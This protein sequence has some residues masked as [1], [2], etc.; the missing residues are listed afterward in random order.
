MCLFQEHGKRPREKIGKER[1]C[2]F[3]QLRHR[4]ELKTGRPTHFTPTESK[5]IAL[6]KVLGIFYTLFCGTV[7]C[8]LL[9]GVLL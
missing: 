6:R 3:Y 1:I 2:T 9:S 4:S 8:P 7:L 5:E